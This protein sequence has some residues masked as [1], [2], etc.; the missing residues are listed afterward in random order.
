MNQL[1]KMVLTVVWSLILHYNTKSHLP[2]TRAGAVI[3]QRLT[4]EGQKVIL[5]GWVGVWLLSA[6]KPI[7]RPGWWK[8]TLF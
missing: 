3:A 2:L 1:I 7:N 8:R 5:K 6:Q 4:I